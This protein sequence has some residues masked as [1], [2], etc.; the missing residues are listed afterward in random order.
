MAKKQLQLEIFDQKETS[1]KSDNLLKLKKFT[2]KNIKRI[3]SS[4]IIRIGLNLEEKQELINAYLM[5]NKISKIY[6]FYWPTFKP[7]FSLPIP[8]EYIEYKNIIMYVYFYRLLEE[9]DE[10]SL[11]IMDEC[12]RTQNRSDLTYNC[13]HHYLNQT[14]H[15]IIFEYFPIIE[16]PND[17]MILLDFLNKGK[18]KGKGFNLDLLKDED[19]MIKKRTFSMD[20]EEIPITQ[21]EKESYERKKETLFDTLGSKDP[22]TIPRTLQIFVGSFKKK[23]VR[24][25]NQ[26]IA[27]N[28]R[29]NLSNVKTYKTFD[30]TISNQILIDFPHRRID[31]NDYL[32]Q[33][34]GD[35][36]RFISTT[37]PIDMYYITELEI[38]IKRVE[39]FYANAKIYE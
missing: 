19:I 2:T 25:E 27:R 33:S 10:S 14:S 22:D 38:W 28:A 4:E 8:T 3:I 17:F 24:S 15:K 26:Y 18:Y 11:I 9:I 5:K 20:I 16:N 29:F 39:E 6:I 1:E 32:K 30:N 35:I 34:K 21:K 31:L 12:M 23:H 37:L 13:A 36:I 7:E